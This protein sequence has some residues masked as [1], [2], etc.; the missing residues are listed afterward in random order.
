MKKLNKNINILKNNIKNLED[1]NYKIVA[2]SNEYYKEIDKLKKINNTNDQK[3]QELEKR[4]EENKK[5]LDDY[6]ENRIET[7]KKLE[8]QRY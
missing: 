3:T 4:L 1:R 8:N 5:Y 7:E 2:R 6:E